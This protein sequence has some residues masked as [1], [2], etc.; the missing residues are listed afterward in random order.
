MDST[1][2]TWPKVVWDKIEPTPFE[3]PVC[4]PHSR[5]TETRTHTLE[6]CEV[7]KQTRNQWASFC[8][9]GQVMAFYMPEAFAMLPIT[10]HLAATKGKWRQTT[11][12]KGLLLSMRTQIQSCKQT[13]HG[14]PIFAPPMLGRQKQENSWD[15]RSA[16]IV[17]LV[18]SWP[19]R[20]CPKNTK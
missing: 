16:S 15:F 9:A 19:V 11:W 5:A 4:T 7:G 6:L 1:P 14:G 2:R 12:L 3:V 20:P 17:Q 18:S 13:S 10:S 8:A